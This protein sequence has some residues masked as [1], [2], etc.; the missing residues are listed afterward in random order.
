MADSK[1]L[2]LIG[3]GLGAVTLLVTLAAAALVLD[4]TLIAADRPTVYAAAR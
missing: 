2:R 1:S 3:Y 4:A